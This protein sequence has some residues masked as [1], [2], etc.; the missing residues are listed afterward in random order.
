MGSLDRRSFIGSA[1]AGGAG[2][3]LGGRAQATGKRPNIVLILADDMG[4]SDIGCYGSE[5]NTPAINRLASGG[6][7]FNRFYNAAR[8]CPT[9]ASL[10]TGLYPH[11]AGV[12]HMT[13]DR[14]TPGYRGH[15][16]QD[17]VTLG[18]AMGRA[19]YHTIMSGKWHVGSKKGRW[20]ADRGF[21]E[22]YGI[23]AGSSH[24]FHPGEESMLAHNHK[25]VRPGE[26]FYTT[27][28]FTD[29]AIRSIGECRKKDNNPFFLYLAY[30]APH[31]PLHAYEE[32]VKK[33]EGRYKKG[34]D[35]LRQERYR[36]MKEM[37]IIEPGWNLSERDRATPPWKA[38]TPWKKEEMER[39]MAVYAAMVDR[40]DQDINKLL[41]YLESTGEMDNTLILFLSDNGACHE[42]TAFGFDWNPKYSEGFF[43]TL[44]ARPGTPESFCS[45]GRGWSNAGNTPFRLHKHWTHEGGI[46]TP[47]IAYWPGVISP[48]GSTD[49]VGHVID[50]MA[51]C[52]D[53]AGAD[54]P[55]TF[56]GNDIQ[57]LEG[58]SLLP[59]LQGG[60]R[61]GHDALF[62]E[63]EGN[64]AVIQGRW[65]LVSDYPGGF[66]LYDL[67][68]DRTETRNLAKDKKQKVKEL[69]RM[70][71]EWARRS[72]VEPWKPYQALQY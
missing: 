53:A 32:D 17:C 16:K 4:Y 28:A 50:L 55:E 27:D 34:W 14:G 71:E 46:A 39:K 51:T 62:W 69:S 15:L 23:I 22:H 11:Q 31:W 44:T 60:S 48:G 7:R 19:G 63:H 24:Y 3:A 57:P 1:A 66:E 13:H 52:L 68:E 26:D 20:P 54:Y 12:G 18:E 40:M 36:R 58:K 64:K 56:A 21:G 35:R 67:V 8:C 6:L 47:L 65:K 33:Y 72:H 30:N 29:H 25:L 38:L 59:V 2:L 37:G 9:R 45:Y 5:I 42:L 70:Y 61:E 41:R 49:E 10:L 43:K